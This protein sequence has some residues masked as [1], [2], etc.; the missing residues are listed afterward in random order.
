[1]YGQFVG[2]VCVVMMWCGVCELLS[3]LVSKLFCCSLFSLCAFTTEYKWNLNIYQCC[4]L[5]TIV[6]KG[7]RYVVFEVNSL[8]GSTRVE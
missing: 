1:M 3:V 7:V 5:G 2:S 4:K 8:A 6:R